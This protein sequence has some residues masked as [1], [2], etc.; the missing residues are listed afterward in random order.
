MNRHCRKGE[1]LSAYLDGELDGKARLELEAHLEG[2][3]VCTEMLQ[4]LRR[5]QV[6]FRSLP[7]L[8]VGFDLAPVVMTE[9]ARRPPPARRPRFGFHLWQLLPV[10]FAAAATVSLGIF[11]G[12]S[13]T[14]RP[15]M[16]LTSAS[17]AI[18]DPIPPGGI[19][20]G[21]A[22]CYPKENI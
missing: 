5:L 21:L 20:I 15:D 4:G 16:G 8:E 9:L 7:E 22:S 2:C 11:L 3:P 12:V 1:D 10:S 18:F 19:C 6:C 13:L 17:L 14:S